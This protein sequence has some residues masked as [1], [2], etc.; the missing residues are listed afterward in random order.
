MTQEVKIPNDRI[1]AIFGKGGETRKHLEKVLKVTLDVD[2]QTG[3]VEITNENDALAEIR[4][5][6]VIKAIGRGFSP[7]RAKKL[8]EDED[9][10]LDIIDVTDVADT[11]DKLARIR[12]RIIGRD[13]KA[14]EQI[15]N[16]T[17]TSISVYGKTVAIIGLPEQ[18]NDAHTAVSMLISGS[19]HTTVFSYLDRKRKEAKMDMMSYY[20]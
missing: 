18:M 20:Y 4:S 1:G 19:E 5:M 16:M 11:P 2:S 7:E 9:M 8:L 3:I 13:G 10:V 14:R 15:E 12:G 17:G 6:E